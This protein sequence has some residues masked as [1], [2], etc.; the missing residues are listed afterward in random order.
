MGEGGGIMGAPRKP[1]IKLVC[2][3]CKKAFTL[4]NS[5]YQHRAW[6][7][8]SAIYC[9]IKCKGLGSRN[10]VNGNPFQIS[11]SNG[12]LHIGVPMGTKPAANGYRCNVKDSG[13]IVYTPIVRRS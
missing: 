11:S 9:S 10:G 5:E 12:S 3:V 6:K 1:R 4:S 8:K 7:T 2:P 13:E